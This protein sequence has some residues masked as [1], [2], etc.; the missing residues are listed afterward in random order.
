MAPL[1]IGRRTF[2]SNAGT[3][4][5]AAAALTVASVA[6]ADMDTPMETAP[7]D[8]LP[9]HVY[10]TCPECKGVV[11]AFALTPDADTTRKALAEDIRKQ[12]FLAF[13]VKQ[14]KVFA[15]GHGLK[16]GCKRNHVA[17]TL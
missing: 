10:A 3:A 14:A 11:K 12:G 4:A 7:Q 1:N 17:P 13:Q 6:P 8:G 15:D 5:V 2:L 16:R 9:W